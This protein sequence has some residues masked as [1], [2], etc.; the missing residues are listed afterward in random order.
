MT[1]AVTTRISSA[2]CTTIL[3]LALGVAP[4]ALRAQGITSAA[5]EGR[6]LAADMTPA[7]GAVVRVTS[8][9]SGAAWQVVTDARGRY[10]LEN[11]EAGGP[12]IVE[13]RRI[14]FAASRRGGITLT[15]GHRHRVDFVLQPSPIGLAAVTISAVQNPM[16]H[17]GRTGP[18]HIISGAELAAL[19]NITRDL[20]TMAALA[21]LAVGRPMGGIS[22]GGQNQG[23]NNL[24][25]DG[26]VNADLYLGR[27]PGSASPSGALPEVLPRAISLETV[28]EFQV[29]VAPFDVRFGSFAGGLLNAVTKSG[30]NHVEGSL[31]GFVQNGRLVG[32]N[33]VGQRQAFTTSQFGGTVAGPI[34]RDRG[35]Y[36]VNADVQRRIVPDP[37]PLIT[38][39]GPTGVSRDTAAAFREIL[40]R[41]Y[42]LDAG[43]FSS[44]GRVPAH[45]LF[46]KTTVQLGAAGRVELS[47][48]Y[49]QG[50]RR[51]FLDVNRASDSTALSSVATANRSTTRTSRVIW[52]ALLRD[53]VQSEVIVSHQRL[54]D[55]CTPNAS[56]PLIQVKT[57]EGILVAGPNSVCPTTDVQQ[58]AFE[59]TGNLTVGLG[60]HMLTFGSHAEWLHFRDPLVQVS[61]GRWEFLSLDSLEAGT[62]SHYDRGLPAPPPRSSG[63]DFR[64]RGIGAYVQDRWAPTARLTLTAGLRMDIPFMPDPAVTN[65]ALTDAGIDTGVLPDGEPSWSPRLGI[66]YDVRGDGTA[67]VRGG[68]GL[69]AGPPPYRW[70]GNAYRDSGDEILV[71]C[72]RPFVPAF[73][74]WS[75]PTRC[76]NG[77]GTSPRI[78]YFQPGFRFPQNLKVAVGADRRLPFDLTASF[79]VLYT[80]SVHGVAIT[81]ANLGAPSGF[82]SWEENRPL[83]GSVTIVGNR[84]MLVPAWLTTAGGAREIYRLSNAGGDEALS[85]SVQAR[86]QLG[87]AI[88][89]YASYAHSRVRD[90]MSMINLPARANFSNTP[91]DGTLDDRRLRPSFFET[92]HKVALAATFGRSDGTQ[93]SLLY[94]GASQPPFT[95]VINGDANGDGIG[96]AGSLKNDIVYVPRSANDIALATPSEYAGLHAFIEQHRCL[97]EQRGRI[98]ERGSCRNGWLSSL[99]ARVATMVPV[100]GRSRLG[101][102]ADIYNVPNL[103][104]SRW[105][106]GR[107]VTTGPTVPLLQLAAWDA[108]GRASYNVRL[109]AR[110]IIDDASSR[111]RIQLG[112]RYYLAGLEN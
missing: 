6:V 92:P 24:Q 104:S 58:N 21:P 71:N 39:D 30:T 65:A 2:C 110:G 94:I 49:A 37:G 74:P 99:S 102:T 59:L 29:L 53:A 43:S 36:F 84:P 62:A 107:D 81:N 8:V 22:I 101:I 38:A 46:G 96:G 77:G 50:E 73:D 108:A 51:G 111:W 10:F 106:R 97:R 44:D 34:V 72:D 13:A 75:Q 90:R 78:S 52:N 9:A 5:L 85:V 109:P 31:F 11:V 7:E 32:R 76:S 55:R 40:A 41:R 56:F 89:M 14:G 23:F 86:K 33:A 61:A 19:P 3:F 91:L 4:D 82:A 26:G 66:N 48:H 79:D 54:G 105:G 63:V 17:A 83:Y 68:I 45:D 103:L 87:E 20:G 69:F 27:S 18:E 80:R 15:L 98:M 1:N 93:L 70:L 16:L 12:Y 64:V 95:Y 47:H 25:V 42:G 60:Q 35:H 67:F 57:T 112:A 88:A 100:P 28:R